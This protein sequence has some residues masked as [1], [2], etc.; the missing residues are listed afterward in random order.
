VGLAS[1]ASDDDGTF[2]LG[3]MPMPRAKAA[4]HGA[5]GT[6]L[7]NVMAEGVGL[8]QTVMLNEGGEG[9]VAGVGEGQRT[10]AAPLPVTV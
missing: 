5:T 9:A 4:R 2:D 10:A 7:G 3:P 6:V 1:L 8:H